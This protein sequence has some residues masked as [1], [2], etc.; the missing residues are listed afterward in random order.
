MNAA[1]LGLTVR[2]T[3]D[4]MAVLMDYSGTP[5]DL[6][7]LATQTELELQIL[8]VPEI[9]PHDVL[10]QRL[11]EAVKNG[12]EL[13][14][15]VLL[16]G[17]PPTPPEH[18]RIEWA[19]D[20]FGSGFAIDEKTGAMDYRQPATHPAVE[21]GQLLA[22]V[23]AP[24]QGQDGKDVFGRPVPAEKPK[25]ALILPGPHVRVEK[26][27]D[28]SYFYAEK[29][30]RV[31]WASNTLAVD[32]VYRIPTSV[33]LETGNIRHPGSVLI[34]GDVSAGSRV[35]AGGNIEVKGT[36]E[37]ADI[38]AGGSLKV[39]GG[40]T[41]VGAQCI[42]VEG[43][44][45]AKY[46]LDAHI[47]A[48]EDVVVE[49][50]ILQSTIKTRGSL[51]MPQGRLV[52]GRCTALGG[53]VLG[54]AGS[55]GSVPTVLTAA[56]DHGLDEKLAEIKK[57]MVAIEKNL[58]KIHKKVD[59]LIPRESLLSPKRREAMAKLLAAATE[60]EKR[61]QLLR[62]R[63]EDIEEDSRAR[64]K[65]YIYIK[66]KLYPETTL[67]IKTATLHMTESLNG[68]LRVVAVGGKLKLVPLGA[69][70]RGGKQTD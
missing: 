37:T 17:T 35:E 52:G 50:E 23:I 65:P 58:E 61:L 44:V 62:R 68:P 14:N 5:E 29:E 60:M 20:F 1:E 49:R 42:K 40:I 39:H 27:D 66:N 31:R 51:S 43:S 9:P 15:V 45:S 3:E 36:V 64:T 56:E 6:A 16:E 13:S 4:H 67:R 28:G 53:V 7:S 10:E 54:Q 12:K 18:E 48:G 41:G 59:P 69:S 11:R 26:R 2:V 30:G 21:G 55:E 25:R 34:E 22:R 46:V 24:K 33:G 38:Q 63:Q 70:E 57:Q 19:Q 47:E 8:G 32:E